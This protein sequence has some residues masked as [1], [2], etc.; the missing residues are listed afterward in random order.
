MQSVLDSA[1]DAFIRWVNGPSKSANRE[2]TPQQIAAEQARLKAEWRAKTQQ[3]IKEMETEYQKV[4]QKKVDERKTRI[5]AGLKGMDTTNAQSQTPG[6]QQL[7]CNAD[8]GMKAAKALLADDKKEYSRFAEK[9]DA[10]AMAECVKALPLPPEPGFPDDFR[11]DLYE[12]LTEE[13]NLRLPL[14]EQAQG[15]QRQANDMVAEKQRQVEALKVKQISSPAAEEKPAT[16]DLLA[17]ALKELEAANTLKKE[18]D[19]ALVKLKLE[20]DALNEVGQI[21]AST[22]K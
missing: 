1:A 17:A 8:W 5:L 20:V 10:A 15:Q 12:T 6:L 18:A 16:D 4:Q 3:Q 11:R 19:S 21:A 7:I 13:I 9:P 14:I 2:P 22:A